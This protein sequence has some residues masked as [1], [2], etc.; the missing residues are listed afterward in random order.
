VRLRTGLLALCMF[1]KHGKNREPI[2]VQ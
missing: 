1:H 2:A